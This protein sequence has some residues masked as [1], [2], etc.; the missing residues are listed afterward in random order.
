[1]TA[2]IWGVRVGVGEELIMRSCGRGSPSTGSDDSV[3]LGCKRRPRRRWG[4]SA[5]PCGCQRLAWRRSE[6]SRALA[7]SLELPTPI[8]IE[9]TLGWSKSAWCCTVNTASVC[10]ES[11]YN[12]FSSRGSQG[13]EWPLQFLTTSPHSCVR[14]ATSVDRAPQFSFRCVSNTCGV[15]NPAML[16]A[17]W[18]ARQRSC[19]WINRGVCGCGCG[20]GCGCVRGCVRGCFRFGFVLPLLLPLPL[21][22]Y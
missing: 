1:M 9:C 19:S 15:W 20:C 10:G 17:W 6:F 11:R 7:P 16:R 2:S 22:L 4:A 8:G 3:V 14:F 18:K 13:S 5:P 21:L 12:S